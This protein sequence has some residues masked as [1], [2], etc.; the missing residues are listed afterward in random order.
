MSVQIHSVV[1]LSHRKPVFLQFWQFFTFR[2]LDRV[3][4]MNFNQELIVYTLN[5]DTAK[6]E[7]NVQGWFSKEYLTSSSAGG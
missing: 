5:G 2:R 7:Y 3:A 4:I 1:S 6:H